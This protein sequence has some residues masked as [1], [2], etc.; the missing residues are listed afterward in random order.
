M[1]L[2]GA[3]A[4]VGKR[5][6]RPF[7]RACARRGAVLPAGSVEALADGSPARKPSSARQAVVPFLMKAICSGN[8]CFARRPPSGNGCFT[9]PPGLCAARSRPSCGEGGSFLCYRQLSEAK[10]RAARRAGERLPESFGERG[11]ADALS[12]VIVSGGLC[13]GDEAFCGVKSHLS[14]KNASMRD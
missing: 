6:F 11:R 5:V 9:L 4:V 13:G 12:D 1:Q 14:A 3:Q 8:S 7:R 10:Q 2:N